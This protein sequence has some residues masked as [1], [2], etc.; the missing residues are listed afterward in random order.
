[1]RFI[2]KPN[3]YIFAVLKISRHCAFR[4]ALWVPQTPPSHDVTATVLVIAAL[5]T[6]RSMRHVI[7]HVIGSLSVQRI[8]E[9]GKFVNYLG[10]FYAHLD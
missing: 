1:M 9:D 10:N 7:C 2:L 6:A 8:A 5:D 3:E 4:G